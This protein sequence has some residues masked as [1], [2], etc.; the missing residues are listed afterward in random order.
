MGAKRGRRIKERER[1][2]TSVCSLKK[3]KECG[4]E[5]V[6]PFPSSAFLDHRGGTKLAEG[7]ITVKKIYTLG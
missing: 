5:L 1:K 6:S 7:P 2:C 3:E 4:R